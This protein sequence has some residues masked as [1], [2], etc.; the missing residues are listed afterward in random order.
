[1]PIKN[2]GEYKMS[3]FKKNARAILGT[4]CEDSNS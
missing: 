4:A 1:V 3:L 2:Y